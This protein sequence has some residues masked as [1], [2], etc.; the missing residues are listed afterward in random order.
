[1][2]WYQQAAL[3]DVAAFG[4]LGVVAGKR[5]A[6]GK[7][8]PISL[9]AIGTGIETARTRAGI[10]AL[11]GPM[12]PT[13][14]FPSAE[15]LSSE[16]FLDTGFTCARDG[17]HLA[18]TGPPAGV[19]AV[20]GYCFGQAALDTMLANIDAAATVMAVPDALLGQRLAG[21]CADPPATIAA[22]QARGTNPLITGAFGRHVA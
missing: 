6:S 16:T 20:G 2:P 7:P 13:R 4:E 9:G 17:E 3:I 22:L 10:L 12:V 21:R 14:T 11:R 8:A 18:V 1:M 5:D 19:T 15:P